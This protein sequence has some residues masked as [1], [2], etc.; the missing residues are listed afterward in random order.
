MIALAC[1]AVLLFV[2]AKLIDPRAD[3]SRLFVLVAAVVVGT[4]RLLSLWDA[5]AEP[6]AWLGIHAAIFAV[7]AVWNRRRIPEAART[8]HPARVATRL[9]RRWFAGG[10]PVRVVAVAY[11]WLAI[12]AVLHPPSNW[13]SYVYHLTRVGFYLQQGSFDRYE[14]AHTHEVDFPANAETLLLW[15]VAFAGHDR[16]AQLVQWAAAVAAASGVAATARLCGASRRGAS[17]GVVLFLTLPM[18]VFQATS[19]Q[20][21]VVA[22]A[23]ALATLRSAVEAVRFG[24]LPATLYAG[25]AAGLGIGTKGT[26]LMAGPGLAVAVLLECFATP[27]AVRRRFAR[28][29]PLAA[30]VAIGFA[31][32]GSHWLIANVRAGVGPFGSQDVSISVR[33]PTP[34]TFAANTVRNGFRFLADTTGLPTN[35]L[36][37]AITDAAVPWAR[38]NDDWLNLPEATLPAEARFLP[39][40]TH[41]MNEDE[42]WYGPL[43]TLWV[44]PGIVFAFAAGRRTR[45]S[46]AAGLVTACV[47][48]IVFKWQLWAGRLFLVPLGLTLPAVA[49]GWEA[50]A[51][52]PPGDAHTRGYPLAVTLLALVVLVWC[53]HKNEGKRAGHLFVRDEASLRCALRPAFAPVCRWWLDASRGEGPVGFLGGTD[54]W[55]YM[56]FLPD[57]SRRV[58]YASKEP[59]AA[60]E[61]IARGDLLRGTVRLP[62]NAPPPAVT[63]Y[64]FTPITDDGWWAFERIDAPDHASSEG[65]RRP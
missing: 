58:I 56:A 15:T 12:V 6:T 34:R 30:A 14:A 17:A 16:L 8:L 5:L 11:V 33:H 52:R 43:G 55:T 48:L 32:C 7:V 31:A 61:R 60:A 42:A 27:I 50:F 26:F 57:F 40:S 13:D 65:A 18:V 62:E 36:G 47:L 63:G 44:T 29:I 59:V 49:A 53:C 1:D 51:R 9:R 20:N 19:T 4:A 64:R 2:T 23:L 38:A 25:L 46:L 39:R 35:L 22:T 3:P 54:D 10:I 28:L 21:D 45:A 37:K 41:S 24:S